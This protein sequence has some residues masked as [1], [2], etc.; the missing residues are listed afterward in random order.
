[1]KVSNSRTNEQKSKQVQAVKV[2][3]SN[4]TEQKS[5]QQVKVSNLYQTTEKPTHV[6]VYHK[7][8]CG[9][10]F[11]KLEEVMIMCDSCYIL[12]KE[13]RSKRKIKKENI[14]LEI[15]SDEKNYSTPVKS[16]EIFNFICDSDTTQHC[17]KLQHIDLLHQ[18]TYYENCEFKLLGAN[19][20]PLNVKAKGYFKS[21]PQP[22]YVIENLD[23]NLFSTTIADLS[24]LQLQDPYNLYIDNNKIAGFI[25]DVNGIIQ[26]LLDENLQ[27]NLFQY[28]NNNFKELNYYHIIETIF[29]NPNDI[30]YFNTTSLSVSEGAL[31]FVSEGVQQLF[32]EGDHIN[33]SNVTI[34]TTTSL[35]TT[36]NNFNEQQYSTNDSII[37]N[38]KVI[39]T[40]SYIIKSIEDL[41]FHFMEY[42]H[43]QSLQYQYN[44]K[45]NIE[46]NL[47]KYFHKLKIQ[48]LKKSI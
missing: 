42:N 6:D 5:V 39:S 19:V 47:S 2:S 29:S 38:N 23:N 8:R 33:N 10:F 46:S 27:I 18:V 17:C 4:H 24:L 20:E 31:P 40:D 12:Y 15:N 34:S 26:F 32:S 44:K 3:N 30:H 45:K 21:L 14:L 16:K 11:K 43:Y 36:L 9:V 25:T 13:K 28:N 22:I 1:V 41:S 35:P 37:I 7:C 48:N